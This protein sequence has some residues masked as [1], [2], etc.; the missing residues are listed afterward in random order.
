VTHPPGFRELYLRHWEAVLST[1]LRVTGNAAD[2]EDVLQTVFLRLLS[3]NLAPDPDRPAE[4][5][6]RRAAIN[7]SIDLIRKRAAHPEATLEEWRDNRSRPISPV[8]KERV[9]RALAKLPPENAE[10]FVLRYLDG[11]TYEEL[12]EMLGTERGTIASRLHRIRAVLQK[13]LSD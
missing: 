12:A 1:A 5:Y 11:Y 9:R 8:E 7:T 6:L 2:A 3:H 13:D 10:L 4:H